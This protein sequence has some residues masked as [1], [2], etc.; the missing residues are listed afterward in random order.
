[1]GQSGY[2][3]HSD[4]LTG[5]QLYALLQLSKLHGLVTDVLV[6]RHPLVDELM[7]ESHPKHVK[8]A[9][10]SIKKKKNHKYIYSF[11]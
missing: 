7:G 2:I 4:S 10:L 1:M 11:L 5:N 8:V 6:N 3:S 9:H